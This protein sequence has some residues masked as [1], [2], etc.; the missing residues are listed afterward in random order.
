MLFNILKGYL[1]IETSL[2]NIEEFNNLITITAI[3]NPRDAYIF[4]EKHFLL[5]IQTVYCHSSHIFL[6][7]IIVHATYL[8]Y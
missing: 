6:M 2:S 4:I 8:A 7:P 5:K 1:G 3:K